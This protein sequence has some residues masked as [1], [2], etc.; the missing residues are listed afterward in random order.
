MNNIDRGPF[1]AHSGFYYGGENG[2]TGDGFC[3]LWEQLSV[4]RETI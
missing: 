3:R 4:N 2:L 1:Q